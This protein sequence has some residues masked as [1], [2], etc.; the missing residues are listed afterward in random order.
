MSDQDNSQTGPDASIFYELLKLLNYPVGRQLSELIFLSA[1]AEREGG[2]TGYQIQKN[3]DSYGIS[4]T[5]A[6]RILKSLA[7]NEYLKFDEIT[8][9]GRAQ[10][11]YSI[12]P[13]GEDKVKELLAEWEGKLDSLNNLIPKSGEIKDNIKLHYQN[14]SEQI[15]LGKSKD[16]IQGFFDSFKLY[17]KEINRKSYDILKTIDEIMVIL[18]EM[19]NYSPGDLTEAISEKTSWKEIFSLV[20]SNQPFDLNIYRWLSGLDNIGAPFGGKK[21]EK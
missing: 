21:T 18:N 2:I 3:L 16:E 10:K 1:I 17:M 11:K 6:Y 15:Y 12:T 8:E 7:D 13:K 19:S 20:D 4:Q 14:I 9:K 5:S